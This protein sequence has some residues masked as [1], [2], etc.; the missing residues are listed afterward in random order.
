MGMIAHRSNS[1]LMAVAVHTQYVHPA[2]AHAELP[3]DLLMF[4]AIQSMPHLETQ[5]HT[6]LYFQVYACLIN[7]SINPRE[8]ATVT[9]LIVTWLINILC[10]IAS[11]LYTISTQTTSFRWVHLLYVSEKHFKRT[12]RSMMLVVINVLPY[13]A[14]MITYRYEKNFS[15]TIKQ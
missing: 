9:H 3:L 14:T 7:L 2:R 12:Y 5:S 13:N 10:I 4:R 15:Y 6:I 8:V 11:F 1:S